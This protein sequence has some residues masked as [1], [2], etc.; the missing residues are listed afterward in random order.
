MPRVVCTLRCWRGVFAFVAKSACSSKMECWG[1]ACGYQPC[2]FL[3]GTPV[4][5]SLRE[6]FFCLG[7]EEKS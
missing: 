6:L 3:A 2:M 5:G 7:S 4:W 1:G